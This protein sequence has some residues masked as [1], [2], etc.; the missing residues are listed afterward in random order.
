M[1]KF[2][3]IFGSTGDLGSQ[4]AKYLLK[5]DLPTQLIIR[6]GHVEKLRKRIGLKINNV[7]VKLVDV[8]SLFNNN[9]L[10]NIFSQSSIIYDLAGMVS[11]SFKD[12]TYADVL[13]VNSLFAG[14]LTRINNKYNLPIVFASTQRIMNIKN[15]PIAETWVSKVTREFKKY[16]DN[17]D[18]VSET[19]SLKF[20]ISVL[21]L[22][23]IPKGFNIYELSKYIGEKLLTGNKNIF[24][25]RISGC[26]GP[27]CSMRRTIGRLLLARIIGQKIIEKEE[28]RDYIFINDLNR[29]LLKLSKYKNTKVFIKYCCSGISATKKYI[30]ERII[31]ETPEGKGVIEVFEGKRVEVFKP[32]N[33]WFRDF[34]KKNP[35]SLDKGLQ[36]TIAEIK[37]IFSIKNMDSTKERL[38][39]IYDTIRQKTDEQGVDHEEVEKIKNQFFIFKNGGWVAHEAFWKPTGLVFG[40]PFPKKLI[41]AFDGLRH[42]ILNKLDLKPRDYWLPDDENLHSTIVNYSHYSEV[43]MDVV[44]MP[45]SE[46]EKANS[47]IAKYSPIQIQYKGVLVTNNGSVLV[48]GLVSNE[49]L[50]N[51]RKD[52]REAINNIT[53]QT[54]SLAHIKLAQILIDVPYDLV[55]KVNRLYSSKD[56]GLHTFP[57]VQTPFGTTLKFRK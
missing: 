1:Y 56:L 53:Q 16:I 51:L 40:N 13:L 33:K 49:D 9:K 2:Y 52:L 18:S 41:N 35:T 24:I 32:S 47:I 22:N 48:M 17:T 42:E 26:Y 3:T 25:L 29:I 31:E 23:P 46:L 20:I 6:K 30:I 36:K 7:N 55:E 54:Q 50:F 37:K 43:G 45:E 8:E 14:L 39:A 15:N 57:S 19:E 11:L 38:L 34:I 21:K 5:N 27:G 4:F 10:E 28:T 12:N 44:S